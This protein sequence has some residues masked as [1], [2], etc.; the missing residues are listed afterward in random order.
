VVKPSKN[1]QKTWL[2]AMISAVK[3]IFIADTSSP[4]TAFTC[5]KSYNQKLQNITYIAIYLN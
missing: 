2:I 4:H 5:K 1:C 3:G